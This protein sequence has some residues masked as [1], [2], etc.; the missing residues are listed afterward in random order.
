MQIY[1]V[2]PLLS[3]KMTKDWPATQLFQQI[4][5]NILISP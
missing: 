2:I 4:N 1:M 5:K 3:Y